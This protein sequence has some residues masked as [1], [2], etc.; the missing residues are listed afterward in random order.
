MS[1][2]HF[3]DAGKRFFALSMSQSI[4]KTSDLMGSRDN[5]APD[6]IRA[7]LIRW[8]TRGA[9]TKSRRGLASERFLVSVAWSAPR[10]LA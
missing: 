4:L 2:I 10:K 7:R 8:T 3:Q 1:R 9:K 5:H 6:E